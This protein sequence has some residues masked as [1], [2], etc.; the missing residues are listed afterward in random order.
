MENREVQSLD[1]ERISADVRA[2][3]ARL[4]AGSMPN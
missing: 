2:I 4:G 3:A 1:L